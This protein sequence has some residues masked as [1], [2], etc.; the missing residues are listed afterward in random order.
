MI[1]GAHFQALDCH[2]L[3]E[4]VGNKV[5]RIYFSSQPASAPSELAEQI[6]GYLHGRR[7]RPEAELDLAGLSKFQQDVFSIVRSV[8]RGIT[9]TYG[10]V[11]VLA[12]RPGASRAV[13]GAMAANPFAILVPCHRVVAK[14]G[15][16]GFRWGIE[17]KEKLLQLEADRP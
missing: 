13:G 16:G 5:K 12:S 6:I 2:L 10:E 8:P 1:S 15:L 9:I 11:A 3:V 7:P 14:E 4:C 17:L